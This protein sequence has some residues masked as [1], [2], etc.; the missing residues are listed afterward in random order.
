M[1]NEKKE[2][3]KI[4]L[5]G[6]IIDVADVDTV[7]RDIYIEHAKD[8]LSDMLTPD[9]YQD[10]IREKN[11]L[12]RLPD[13]INE[14]MEK[15]DWEAVKELSLRMKDLHRWSESN[16]YMFD[17][18]RKVYSSNFIYI[19]PF[20]PGLYHEAGISIDDLPVIR[21]DIIKKL[22]DIIM[23]DKS[24]N[25]FYAARKNYF[26]SIQ[27]GK[28]G[29]EEFT[30]D[31]I[32]LAEMAKQALEHGDIIKLE[33]LSEQILNLTK[34][35]SRSSSSKSQSLDQEYG[36]EGEERLFEFSD[37]NLKRAGKIGLKPFRIE[38]SP[39]YA[40]LCRHGLRR[41]FKV[42]KSSGWKRIQETD[43]LFKNGVS[44]VLKTRTEVFSKHLIINSMGSRHLP[45]FVQEDLLVEDFPEKQSGDDSDSPLLKLLGFE[46][47]R[48]LSRLAIEHS[49]FING[50][51]I[52][53]DELGLDPTIFKL[54]CIP[55]DIY[56]RL[57]ETME[58]GRHEIWTHFDGYSILQH[59]MFNAMAGGDT[60]FGG[61]FDLVTIGREYESDHVIARFAVVQRKRM[62]KMI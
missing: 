23:A 43:P 27:V 10:M 5:I 11:M 28:A 54:I 16:Q 53:K 32:D 48:G 40:S 13:S 21:K 31:E 51:R 18:G 61:I 24:M 45:D 3:D 26:S 33:E 7:F 59:S 55:S 14:A 25:D 37:N 4:S 1:F 12:A 46:T 56:I 8:L 60:R 38:A 44:D 9:D 42:D 62:L 58:W 15:N 17:I 29:G 41:E 19:N 57:G 30:N 20:S 36:K 52:V 35:S 49:L 50:Y 39:K 2:H 47:R 34:Y 22:E 6:N